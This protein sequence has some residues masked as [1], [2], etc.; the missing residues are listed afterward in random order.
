MSETTL[1]SLVAD[2]PHLSPVAEDAA[3]R[4]IRVGR[5]LSAGGYGA[6]FA[7][8]APG[9]GGCVLKVAGVEFAGPQDI[10]DGD[11]GPFR[12]ALPRSV[13]GIRSP[14]L[15]GPLGTC[16]PATL[17]QASLLLGQACLRQQRAGAGCPLA[18][19]LLVLQ[20][21][22]RAAALFERLRGPC[23]R[24][25]LA[26]APQEARAAVPA[27]ARALLLLHDT[28]G[29]HGDLKPEHIFLDDGRV[30]FIDPLPE[31]CEWA[32]SLGYA[33]PL[34]GP[35]QGR[36]KDLGGMAAILAELWGGTVGWDERFVYRVAN[37]HNGRFSCRGF[38]LGHVLSRMQEGTASVPPAVRSWILEAGQG[39]V[40]A[41]GPEWCRGRLEALEIA[42]RQELPGP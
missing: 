31:Q 5:L 16:A 17:E 14:S 24:S 37:L 6:V 9:Q 2:H 1:G 36:L 18:R 12:D 32:G 29:G 28:F 11:N 38:E 42:V 22:G 15:T 10:R 13:Y 8:S 19:L 21:G 26:E 7:A 34:F 3:R 23:L 40:A 35:D 25:L 30:V 41:E 4:G 33:L 27:I 39:L 20:L